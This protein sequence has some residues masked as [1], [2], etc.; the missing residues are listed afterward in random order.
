MM[1]FRLNGNFHRKTESYTKRGMIMIDIGMVYIEM[2]SSSF[3]MII[4]L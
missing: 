1:F 4:A 3:I 2:R